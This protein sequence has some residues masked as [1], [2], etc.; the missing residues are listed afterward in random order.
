VR[1]SAPSGKER[2]GLLREVGEKLTEEGKP[3]KSQ[4][5]MDVSVSK[6]DDVLPWNTLADSL[7]VLISR[8]SFT[9]YEELI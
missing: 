7:K 6:T 9:S 3:R 1:C 4:W 5:A 2:I 8:L